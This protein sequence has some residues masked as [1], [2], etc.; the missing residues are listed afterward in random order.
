[1]TMIHLGDIFRETTSSSLALGIDYLVFF[2]CFWLHE[3]DLKDT[4]DGPKSKQG[5]VANRCAALH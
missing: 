5:A 2:D 4:I 1:M 3:V